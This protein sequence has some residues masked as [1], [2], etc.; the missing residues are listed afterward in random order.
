M[1]ERLFRSRAETEAGRR[2]YA[3]L[4]AQARMPALYSDLSVPDR[5]DARFEIYTVHL[6]LILRR[7]K[8]DGPQARG[9][10]Q[11]LFDTFVG[12]LDDTL[13][14]LGVGDLS[15]AKKMRR[16]GEA[17]YGRLA[18]LDQALAP[19]AEAQ[20]LAALLARTVLADEAQVEAAG[21]LAGY[22]R[23][24]DAAL[25]TVSTADLLDAR[26]AWPEIRP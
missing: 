17:I 26:I 20:A 11:A 21:P 23:A 9:V 24:A 15:V 14:E 5:I 7:L 18:G 2:L 16:L 22:V 12:A 4:S 1:L 19:E 6:A 8:A 10:S 25:A 3:A 13:R